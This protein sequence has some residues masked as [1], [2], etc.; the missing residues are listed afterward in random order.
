MLKGDKNGAELIKEI[1]AAPSYTGTP[2]LC[3]TALSQSEMRQTAIEPGADLLI[4]KPVSNTDLKETVSL[5][6]QQNKS[7][8]K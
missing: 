6:L 1:K 4:T 5:L 7:E 3:L 2:I 8:I